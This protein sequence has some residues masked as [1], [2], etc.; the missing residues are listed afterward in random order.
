MFSSSDI[1]ERVNTRFFQLTLDDAFSDAR[2]SQNKDLL[3]AWRNIVIGNGLGTGGN[4]AR[5]IGYPAVT[6]SNYVKILVEQGVVGFT[7]FICFLFSSCNRIYKNFK[8]LIPEGAMLLS[9]M[10]AMIGSNS[11]LFSIYIM[12]FWYMMGR[13]WNDNYINSLKINKDM[14]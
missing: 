2:T 10:I 3:N 1:G 13:V 6:D 7:I 14:I 11:L 12:P 8:Y 5:K 9:I 4:E